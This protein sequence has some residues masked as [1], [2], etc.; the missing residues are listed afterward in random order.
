MVKS[1]KLSLGQVKQALELAQTAVGKM[2]AQLDAGNLQSWQVQHLQAQLRLQQNAIIYWGN[3]FRKLGGDPGMIMPVDNLYA[4]SRHVEEIMVETADRV[5]KRMADAAKTKQAEKEQANFDDN[6]SRIRNTQTWLTSHCARLF[7]NTKDHWDAG[8]LV[9]LAAGER[10][11]R[12]L[13]ISGTANVTSFVDDAIRLREAGKFHEADLKLREAAFRLHFAALT[14]DAY[15]RNLVT[16]AERSEAGIKVVAALGMLIASGGTALSVGG[17]M[18]VAASGE[19]AMQ[20]TLLALKA[21][22][23][24]EQVTVDDV[25]TAYLEVAIA[26]GSAGLGKYAEGIGKRAVPG[27][28]KKLLLRDPTKQEVDW[29]VKRFVNYVSANAGYIAKKLTGLDK[30]KSWN[31]WLTII[32]PMAGEIPVELTKEHSLNQTWAN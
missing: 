1:V 18:A 3:Q 30:E 5:Q 16:G 26:A 22:D 32:A 15:E 20:G 24:K 17:A 31:I 4:K 9:H 12:P 14:L 29:V 13:A 19:Y 8:Q 6:V 10:P 28:L 11:T 21:A 2:N 7:Q 27:V 23:G 25:T